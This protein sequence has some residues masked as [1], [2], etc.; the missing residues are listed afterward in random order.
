MPR[1]APIPFETVRI[2]FFSVIAIVVCT[3]SVALAA[4]GTAAFD[5]AKKAWDDGEIDG[6]ERAYQ[7]ALERGGLDHQTTLDAWVHLG[8]A[9]AVLGNRTGALA[10]FRMAL[11]IDDSF[12]VPPEAGKKA[13]ALADAARHQANR[14]PALHLS[15]SA[16]D[17]TPS[18]EP[19]AVN[20]VLAAGQAAIVA[21]FSLHVEDKTTA[22]KFDYE[23][24]P[25]GAVVHF[26]IPASMTLPSATLHVR[27]N[28]L[29]SHDN[30]LATSEQTIT[31]R[32][33]P[34]AERHPQRDE[35]HAAMHGGFWSTAWP[36]VIGGVLVAAGGAV[37]GYY[38]LKPPD[39]VS[40]GVPQTN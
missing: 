1:A 23:E 24:E 25:S 20:V 2:R 30:E 32:P 18:G 19:F 13:L 27:V 31:V 10:A 14:V 29:D 36:W 17:E 35:L 4:P 16:P 37:G 39:R 34:I 5:R 7:E 33:T 40:I 22:K 8:A 21:R 12:V 3:S 15:L 38:L 11:V 9:R 6:A 28:A 26:R